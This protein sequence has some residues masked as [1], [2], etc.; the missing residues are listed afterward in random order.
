M[1]TMVRCKGNRGVKIYLEDQIKSKN[2]NEIYVLIIDR[3]TDNQYT[4]KTYLEIEKLAQ[5]Y[6]NIILVS[7]GC[8][9]RQL[10]TYSKLTNIVGDESQKN[11]RFTKYMMRNSDKC[12]IIHDIEYNKEF[13]SFESKYKYKTSEAIYKALYNSYTNYSGMAFVKDKNTGKQRLGPCLQEQ[14]CPFR[15]DMIAYKKCKIHGS[16]YVLTKIQDIV[17]NQEL[18]DVLQDML[19]K[20]SLLCRNRY[21]DEKRAYYY[22]NRL[23]STYGLTA[24]MLFMCNSIEKTGSW[25]YENLCEVLQIM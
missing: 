17:S 3:M 25:T 12:G 20:L 7:Y 5:E 18:R 22:K 6:E 14:C 11:Y 1:F 9:E 10:L 19:S 23:I 4:C 21:T 16:Y 13:S 8:L 15:M 2:L 24:Q